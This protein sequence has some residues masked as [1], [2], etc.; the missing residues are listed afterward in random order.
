LRL[1]PTLVA[2]HRWLLGVD[3]G[4]LVAGAAT[5]VGPVLASGPGTR[6]VLVPLTAKEL[7]VLVHLDA[8]ARTEDIAAAMFITVNTVRTHIRHILQ[9]LDASRRNEAVRRARE[10][11]LVP[12]AGSSVRAPDAM[13]GRP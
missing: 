5:P 7:E 8:L 13:A 12:T 10:L 2:A 4:T 11:G 1:D 3:R 6:A 9:K